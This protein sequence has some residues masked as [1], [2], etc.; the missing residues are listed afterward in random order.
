MENKYSKV[1]ILIISSV[2]L[3]ALQG[4]ADTPSINPANKPSKKNPLSA[5]NL[6]EKDQLY[7]IRHPPYNNSCH[8][9]IRHMKSPTLKV[10]IEAVKMC[11]VAIKH[12]KNPSEIVQIAAVQASSRSILFI[13]SPSKAALAAAESSKIQ[14][15]KKLVDSK[16][17][18][19][20]QIV[21]LLTYGSLGSPI[22][23][24]QETN[25]T[26]QLLAV[27]KYPEIIARIKKPHPSVKNHPKVRAYKEEQRTKELERK[28]YEAEYLKR[29]R[30]NPSSSGPSSTTTRSA[31]QKTCRQVRSWKT[32]PVLGRPGQTTQVV[33]YNEECSY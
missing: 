22:G 14:E 31:P 19:R 24:W 27:S 4:C 10:Q 9:P 16:D 7:A 33:E 18:N 15:M 26:I 28:K 3:L 8:S 25:E 1:V 30:A 5:D 29:R 11:S 13:K 32:V 2:A 23:T 12:V 21:S 6:S 20:D 17:K